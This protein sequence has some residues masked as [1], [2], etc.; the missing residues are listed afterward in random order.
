M[1]GLPQVFISAVS[2]D[3]RTVRKAVRDAVSNQQWHPVSQDHFD[4]PTHRAVAAM[5]RKKIEACDALIHIVGRAYGFEPQQREPDDRRRSYTQL[6]YD[7]ACE[8]QRDRGHL[9][10]LD[11]ANCIASLATSFQ[12]LTILYPPAA[13]ISGKLWI[14]F[15]SYTWISAGS[16]S[17]ETR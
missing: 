10:V 8:L 16:F 5:L 1:Q 2:A 14:A 12:L 6:E 7:I 17:Q 13:R 11:E 9:T 3:L 4:V 15:K